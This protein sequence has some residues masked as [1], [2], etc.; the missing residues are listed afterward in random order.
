MLPS[1]S[2]RSYSRAELADS[3]AA[4]SLIT[5]EVRDAPT[6]PDVRWSSSRESA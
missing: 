3:L 4:A 6:G 1:D 5:D 2:L